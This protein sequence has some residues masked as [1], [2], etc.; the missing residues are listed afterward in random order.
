M[1]KRISDERLA[2]F[3]L[4]A[5]FGRETGSE[6][7]EIRRSDLDVVA[8]EIEQSRALVRELRALA[9]RMR[10]RYAD[11]DGYSIS[12]ERLGKEIAT[13]EWLSALD[14]LLS[15]HGSAQPEAKS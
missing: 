2:E 12:A 15:A 8:D 3:R 4:F 6:L 11:D 7:V 13:R 10:E 9:E 1:S 14:S 5:K